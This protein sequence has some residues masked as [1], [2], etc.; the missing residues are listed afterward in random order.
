MKG[1]D[2]VRLV[3]R[4]ELTERVRERSFLISTGITLVIIVLVVVLPTLLGFG[5]PSEYTINAT[6][7]QDRAVAERAVQLADEF[8]A[9]VTIGG[10]NADVTL[11]GGVIRSDEPPDEELVSLLQVANQQVGARPV[12]PLQ[13]R[14]AEPEDPDEDAKAG[15][16]FFAILVLYGQLLTYGYWVATGVVEEKAS[17]VIEVLLATIRP[18]HLLAG[19][20]IGLGLLGLGQLLVIAV[21][22]VA[23]AA[24]TG[25]FE[26]DGN[27][28]AGVALSLVWF[29]L[30]YAFYAS[31][32]AV[33]G[34]LVPRQEEIQSST[35]PLTMLILISLFAGFAVNENP[36]GTLGHVTAFLP[37]TSPRGSASRLGGRRNRQRAG[38]APPQR[39]DVLGQVRHLDQRGAA[40]DAGE[41]GGLGALDLRGALQAGLELRPRGDHD[42][43]VVGHDHVARVHAH[44]AEEDRAADARR[45]VA[46]S[47]HRHR[48]ACPQRQL[49]RQTGAVTHVA[50]DHDPA[51]PA[52]ERLGREQLAERR[53]RRPAG[54]YDQHVVRRGLADRVQHGQ[55]LARRHHRVRGPA[56]PCRGQR[57]D[58]RIGDRQR[59]VDVAERADRHRGKGIH[60]QSV[61]SEGRCA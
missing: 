1:R 60:R 59:L 36:D 19:K 11:S 46:A 61:A 34:A 15:L 10:V 14:S 51:Q 29:V 45:D 8:D 6:G 5:G 18:I 21:C 16:A 49:G 32:Y 13:V 54:L 47:R 27:L 43:V 7:P 41:H 31:A 3:A 37:P 12:P 20:V 42:P 17:R 44:A 39:R 56:Q 9:T 33:A 24:G 40:L 52:A 30:G 57:P 55:E 28:I 53:Q 48:P 38:L 58:R 50:V 2:A 25:A 22:G 4:R 35:M 26:I 23:V